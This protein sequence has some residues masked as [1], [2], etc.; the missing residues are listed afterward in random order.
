MLTGV[1]MATVVFS[2]IIKISDIDTI[3]SI[4]VVT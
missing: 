1:G 3:R 2:K 4:G